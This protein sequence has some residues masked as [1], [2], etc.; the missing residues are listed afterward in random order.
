MP[1]TWFYVPALRAIDFV[2]D[3]SMWSAAKHI[4][5]H[6]VIADRGSDRDP[7]VTPYAAFVDERFFRRYPQWR[8]F[9]KDRPT[10]ASGLDQ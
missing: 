7:S 3:I 9:A 6:P 1:V 10:L 2:T 5:A 8:E 4:D